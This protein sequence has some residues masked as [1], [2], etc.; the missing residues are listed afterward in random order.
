MDDLP[1]Y[2][3]IELHRELLREIQ[4]VDSPT[5]RTPLT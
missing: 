2:R 5:A 3:L 4:I 1:S